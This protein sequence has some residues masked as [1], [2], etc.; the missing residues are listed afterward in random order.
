[1][2]LALSDTSQDKPRERSGSASSAVRAIPR[3][4]LAKEE[5]IAAIIE[6]SILWKNVAKANPNPRFMADRRLRQHIAIR[7]LLMNREWRGMSL[8]LD[9]SFA[10]LR[11]VIVID[12]PFG[13]ESLWEWWDDVR[14]NPSR[15][16]I[17]SLIQVWAIVTGSPPTEEERDRVFFCFDLLDADLHIDETG[18]PMGPPEWTQGHYVSPKVVTTYWRAYQ[19]KWDQVRAKQEARL[20]AR[21]F[22]AA[23]AGQRHGDLPPELMSLIGSYYTGAIEFRDGSS[24][25]SSSQAEPQAAPGMNASSSSGSSS[26]SS[27]SSSAASL[28]RPPLSPANQTKAEAA[29]NVILNSTLYQ[30]WGDEMHGYEEADRLAIYNLLARNRFMG[31]VVAL[32]WSLETWSTLMHVYRADLTSDW[33]WWTESLL[34]FNLHVTWEEVIEFWTAIV[35]RP[36]NPD[37]RE[38]TD[39]IYLCLK[40]HV[41][42]NPDGSQRIDDPDDPRYEDVR[43]EILRRIANY[44]KHTAW[45]HVKLRALA[46][47]RERD[48]FRAANAGERHGNIPPDLMNLIGSYYTEAI[49]F[50]DG[51]SSSSAAAGINASSSS[52]SSSASAAASSR[53]SD[54]TEA[55]P[56][57]SFDSSIL[58]P[59]RNRAEVEVFSRIERAHHLIHNSEQWDRMIVDRTVGEIQDLAENNRRLVSRIV[60]RRR[61]G[62]RSIPLD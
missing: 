35:G 31:A 29:A 15:R 32:D 61:L 10:A 5:A 17:E 3:E 52:S 7:R 48:A 14:R 39:Y 58:G 4:I 62:M 9:W 28:P 16:A 49:E 45:Y 12:F 44:E 55:M 33:L 1:M 25:S 51:S 19:P 2:A 42:L 24:S 11:A 38:L 53:A 56:A 8:P 37:E 18:A 43:G 20:Q 40:D 26:S 30:L 46:A 34:Y 23:N 57:V 47:A 21:A 13:N 41:L 50:K 54:A 60:G 22:R 36:P 27:S 59:T 6:Q